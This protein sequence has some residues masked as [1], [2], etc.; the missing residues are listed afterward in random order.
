M[1]LLRR[2]LSGLAV[3]TLGLCAAGILSPRKTRASR[4]RTRDTSA[5]PA[6]DPAQVLS[7]LR[8]LLASVMA[9][10]ANGAAHGRAAVT[11][12]APRNEP[13][14]GAHAE[15]GTQDEP[16]GPAEPDY[17]EHLAARESMLTGAELLMAGSGE[18]EAW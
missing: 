10:S 12:P 6:P 9:E 2:Y 4:R 5:A 17:Y 15:P 16:E 1:V 14:P 11:I 18:E 3:A 8:V 7:D 13:E